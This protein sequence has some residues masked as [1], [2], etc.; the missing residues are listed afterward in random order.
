MRGLYWVRNDLRFHDNLTFS[1]FNEYAQEGIFVWCPTQSFLRADSFRRRFITDSISEFKKSI[2]KRGGFFL[3]S[4]KMASETIPSLV[5]LCKIDAVFFSSE[6]ACEEL[7]E[8]QKIEALDVKIFKQS[9]NSL[10]EISDLPMNVTAVPETFTK[11]RGLVEK[12]LQIREP[13]LALETLPSFNCP[14]SFF[15]PSLILQEIEDESFHADRH[16][17]LNGGE[18]AGLA[19]LHE[20]LWDLDCL[21]KYKETRNGMV[22]WNDSSKLS[23]WLSVGALS[24]R[25][26]YAEVLRY[27]AERVKNESTYWLFFELL[28]RDYF[29]LIAQKW[30]A[31]FFKGMRSQVHLSQQRD[32]QSESFLA[33]CQG[34]TGDDFVDANMHELNQTGWMSN[35]G[36][37][38][39]AS[40]LCKALQVDWRLGASY[41]ESKLI[42]YDVSSNWGNWAYLAGTGQDARNR[43]FDTQRQAALYDPDFA[44]RKLWQ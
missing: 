2:E 38:N 31:D 29:R 40:Y 17:H 9:I 19:R 32:P 41:F 3:V 8:E 42:D 23:A 18:S 7:T 25:Q 20:Y 26:I 21:R 6:P 1:L 12:S 35:R 36:R 34:K 16:P 14:F 5:E 37:Q 15:D 44:Y 30:Q 33:W 4:T 11:F 27:E 22:H 39:V 28:W 10:I 24:P 13:L 43:V